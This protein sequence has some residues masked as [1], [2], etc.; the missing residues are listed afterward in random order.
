MK[1]IDI[2]KAKTENKGER[3]EFEDDRDKLE[4]DFHVKIIN[5][6]LNIFRKL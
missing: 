1:G 3:N 6:I 2:D 4:E 5:Y